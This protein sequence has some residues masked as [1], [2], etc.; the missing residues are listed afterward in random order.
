VVE[1]A[2]KG[3][4]NLEL[5]FLQS[6]F[7]IFLFLFFFFFLVFTEEKEMLILNVEMCPSGLRQHWVTLGAEL[8][9]TPKVPRGL[10]MRP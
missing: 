6:L 5:I 2:G 7:F 4:F 9:D 8:A 10:S 3:R 1:S